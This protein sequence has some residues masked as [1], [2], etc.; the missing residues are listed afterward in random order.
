MSLLKAQV[1]CTL[2]TS[3]HFDL[4]DVLIQKKDLRNIQNTQL[5]QP[6][7]YFK[8]FFT[9]VNKESDLFFGCRHK[10]FNVSHDSFT[11]HIHNSHFGNP[12]VRCLFRVLHPFFILALPVWRWA[13]MLPVNTHVRLYLTK[14]LEMCSLS[15]LCTVFLVSRHHCFTKRINSYAQ[16]QY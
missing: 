4:C 14:C 5:T 3:K 16:N 13:L 15:E 7:I 6:I 11:S 10:Q 1:A 8:H 9:T 12:V 2:S